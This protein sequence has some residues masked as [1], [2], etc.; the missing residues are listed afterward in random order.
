MNMIKS[1]STKI[2]QDHSR[3]L[4][5]LSSSAPTVGSRNDFMNFGALPLGGM[6]GVDDSTGD[7]SG[8]EALVLG[9]AQASPLQD[10]F[11]TWG[12]TST[13]TMQPSL[14]SN[15]RGASPGPTFSWSTP[16]PTMS[17]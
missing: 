17:S 9:K 7:S 3:K 16:S 13:A 11:D 12:S 10:T 5:E 14:P 4:Q 8:F 1:F 6:N 15:S 2:E